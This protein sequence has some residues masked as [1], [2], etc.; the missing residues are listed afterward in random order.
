MRHLRKTEFFFRAV[1]AFAVLFVL[2]NCGKSGGTG[3]AN[4]GNTDLWDTGSGSYDPN[5]FGPS[6]PATGGGSTGNGGSG[7]GGGLTEADQFALK[8]VFQEQSQVAPQQASGLS[9]SLLAE[10][11]RLLEEEAKGRDVAVAKMALAGRMLT[12][13]AER[14][15]P[16]APIPGQ[17]LLGVWASTDKAACKVN[18][19][20]AGTGANA[21]YQ[22]AGDTR[23][24]MKATNQ[25]DGTMNTEPF[26]GRL[27]DRPESGTGT[28]TNPQFTK[29][30]YGYQACSTAVALKNSANPIPANYQEAMKRMGMCFRQALVLMSPVF[31]QMFANMNPQLRS[32]LQQRMLGI[33]Q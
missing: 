16:L 25:G 19:T 13:C 6:G 22:V 10:A 15:A 26:S 27:T 11:K 32:L 30:K 28:L 12:E 20:I 5:M 2:S 8:N 23:G 3:A 9:Q 17:P 1:L 7:S 31:D 14:T 29:T 24:T 33:Q 18:F 21:T 4:Q